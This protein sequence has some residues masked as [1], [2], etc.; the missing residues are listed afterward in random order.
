[1]NDT[2]L[3]RISTAEPL[4][5]IDAH[6]LDLSDDVLATT[7]Y[8]QWFVAHNYRVEPSLFQ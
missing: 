3:Y 4:Y 1:M 8:I 2:I 6:G 7:D 5:R